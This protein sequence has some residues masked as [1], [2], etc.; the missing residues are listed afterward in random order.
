MVPMLAKYRT[1]VVPA[2]MQRFGYKNRLAVPRLGK[3]VLSIGLGRVTEEKEKLQEALDDLA[4]ITGQ[5]AVA[6]KARKSVAGFKIREGMVIGAMVTLRG[7]RMYEFLHRLIGVAIPRIRDFRGLNPK[8]FDGHGNFSFGL[9]EQ[10]VFPEIN[11]DKVKVPLGMHITLVTTAK[12]D[13]EGREL[14]R[15][16]GIPY[17]TG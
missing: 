17:A 8:S 2:M 7:A 6:T 14:L 12:T 10:G 15:L 11:P 4:I 1:E 13:E 16:F 9:T 3:I 5:K